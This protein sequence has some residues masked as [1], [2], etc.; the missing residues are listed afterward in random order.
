MHRRCKVIV[1]RPDTIVTIDATIG[2]RYVAGNLDISKFSMVDDS[3]TQVEYSGLDVT[4]VA[5]MVIVVLN[6]V[7]DIGER[8]PDESVHVRYMGWLAKTPHQEVPYKYTSV[9]V[10]E[11]IDR[12]IQHCNPSRKREFLEKKLT[13]LMKLDYHTA[14]KRLRKL[15]RSKCW[16]DTSLAEKWARNLWA[17]RKISRA[18]RDFVWRPASGLVQKLGIGWGA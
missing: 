17:I 2:G 11:I 7:F 12:F 18:V 6:M 16:M 9:R 13:K 4:Q 8:I 5:P 15:Y 1:T 3:L 10:A 14:M